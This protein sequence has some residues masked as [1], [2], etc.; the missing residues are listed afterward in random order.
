MRKL[1]YISSMDSEQSSWQI[2]KEW[3]DILSKCLDLPIKKENKIG[4]PLNGGLISTIFQSQST[5]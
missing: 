1:S 5:L 3:E 4:R 2:L